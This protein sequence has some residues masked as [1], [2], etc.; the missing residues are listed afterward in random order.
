M[1][2]KMTVKNQ[3]TLPKAVVS[4]VATAEY[5]DVAVSDGRIV[6]TPARI[7]KADA[8]REKLAAMALNK[9]DIED[10][11]NWARRGS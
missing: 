2:A 6:L 3:I 7:Q 11:V 5:F 1:L 8:V 9:Q 10:A 4:Q